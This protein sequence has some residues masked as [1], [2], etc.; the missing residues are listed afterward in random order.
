M[1]GGLQSSLT[2]RS[3]RDGRVAAQRREEGF[4]VPSLTIKQIA[5]LANVSR[6]TVSR[7]LNNHPSVRPEVRRRIDDV[8]SEQ[9]YAPRAAARNLARRHSRLI[10]II[11]GESTSFVF[12]TQF[13]SHQID[14]IT[15]ICI[16]RGY[17]PMLSMLTADMNPGIVEDIMRSRHFDGIILYA[18]EA[19]AGLLELLVRE[20]IPLVQMGRLPD[21]PGLNWVEVDD[22]AGA[23]QATQ[24]LIGLG[25]TR[26][27]MITGPQHMTVCIDRLAGYTQALH[28]AGLPV[29][30]ELLVEGDHMQEGGYRGIL[31]LLTLSD[32]PTAIFT[33][34]DPTAYGALQAIDNAGLSVP[35]DI[36]IVGFDDLPTS[37]TTR[38]PLT[39]VRQPISEVGATAATVVIDQLE[40][41]RTEPVHICLPTHL[42]VR[43]SC[44]ASLH[45]CTFATGEAG[46]SNSSAPPPA[47][48]LA[49]LYVMDG[50][51]PGIP[52]HCTT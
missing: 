37:S 2:S 27:A 36:A 48:V 20:Q 45:A 3:R 40:R 50:P 39:T 32:P 22:R 35:D 13:F 38:P 19:N 25:H 33:S 44:G 28:E 1:F 51:S 23:Y 26:I 24:H 8:I 30:P 12:S 11:I 15:R 52:P 18:S 31:R 29:L 42:V 14:A 49:G 21:F 4:N 16:E 34:N 10:G 46:T 6:S 47:V 7:V 9:G 17:Y 5:A 41:K 43:Q